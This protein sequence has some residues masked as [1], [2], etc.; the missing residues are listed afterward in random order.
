MS[1]VL[2]KGPCN[3]FGDGFTSYYCDFDAANFDDN[4]F[5][6][7]QIQLPLQLAKAAKKRRAGFLAGRFCAKNALFLL[8]TSN[9]SILIGEQRNPIWPDG[10]IGS[11]SHSADT[12]VSVVAEQKNLL[13]I[14]IDVEAVVGSNI[15]SIKH[16]FATKTELELIH[17]TCCNAE[18][19]LTALFSSK[20]SFFKAAFPS[21]NRYIDFD[22]IVLVN[23]DSTKQ[24]FDF[25]VVRDLSPRLKAG[26][27]VQAMY[28]K[29]H[30]QQIATLVVIG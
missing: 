5:Y 30:N 2:K 26:T 7:L 25:D 8:G 12:A 15:E 11:I 9:T 19:S 14:G 13:G 18:E 29:I 4:L 6:Q 20:E 1:Y 16:M 3:W 27:R 23:I 28:R 24:V 22:S 17:S 10:I 21:M